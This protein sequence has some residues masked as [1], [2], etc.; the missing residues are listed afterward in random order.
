[1]KESN[2]LAMS[3]SSLEVSNADPVHDII[4]IHAGF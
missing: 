2:A 4:A 1:M 3:G